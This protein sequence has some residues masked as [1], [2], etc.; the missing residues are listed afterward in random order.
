MVRSVASFA[1][2]RRDEAR[3]FE[4]EHGIRNGVLAQHERNEH[5]HRAPDGPV[6]ESQFLEQLFARAAVLFSVGKVFKLAC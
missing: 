1:R 2:E 4:D 5:L 3:P 6:V